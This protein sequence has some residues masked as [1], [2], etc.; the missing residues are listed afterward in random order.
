MVAKNS[1]LFGNGKVVIFRV[2]PVDEMYSFKILARLCFYLNTIAEEFIDIFIVGVK[3][4]V[5]IVGGNP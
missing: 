2:F 5:I 3:T 4:F 1:D